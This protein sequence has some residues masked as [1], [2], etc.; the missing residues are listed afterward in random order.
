M[1]VSSYD[2]VCPGDTVTYECTVSSGCGGTTVWKGDFFQCSSGKKVIELVHRPLT[3]EPE[4][5]VFFPRICND[6]D[7]VGKII[8]VGNDH[9]TSQL[10]VT[11]TSDTAGKSIECVND[12]GTSTHRVGLVNL[13]TG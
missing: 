5:E 1:Q 8:N 11:Q 2:C 7:I 13:T 10:N 4:G 6:G 12:N 3:S 9:F